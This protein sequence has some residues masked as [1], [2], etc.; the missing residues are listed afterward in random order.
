MNQNYNLYNYN[1]DDTCYTW[2]EESRNWRRHQHGHLSEE[3]IQIMN[4]IDSTE[5]YLFDHVETKAEEIKEHFTNA[6][7]DIN[8][9]VVNSKNE[10]KEHVTNAKNE[11]VNNYVAEIKTTVKSNNSIL[12]NIWN[13]INSWTIK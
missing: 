6:K 2:I 10:I 12:N 9:N 11:I 5:K 4:H 8:N 1:D 13:K 3:A 7:N